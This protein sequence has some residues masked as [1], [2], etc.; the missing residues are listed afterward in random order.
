MGSLVGSALN[1]DRASPMPML[2]EKAVQFAQRL[3]RRPRRAEH[4]GGALHWIKHPPGYGENR[5]RSNF[6]MYQLTCGPALAVLAL[7]APA[8]KGVPAVEDLNFLPE[9]GRMNGRWLS[10]DPI[11]YLQAACAPANV[12]P[13]S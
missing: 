11:G 7:E 2:D 12:R 1:T 13:Q 5:A 9:M 3:D 6:D 8:V 4:H 10:E